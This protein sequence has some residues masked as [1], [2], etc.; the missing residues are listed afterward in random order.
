MAIEEISISR[1]YNPETDCYYTVDWFSYGL[2]MWR[3][4]LSRP[5][6]WQFVRY[7][8]WKKSV[9]A[10]TDFLLPIKEAD[11]AGA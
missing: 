7:M 9:P 8:K 4:R 10:F 11:N 1:V 3:W 5:R 6:A 2:T